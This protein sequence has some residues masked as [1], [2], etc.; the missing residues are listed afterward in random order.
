MRYSL[1][2]VA[3]S[4]EVGNSSSWV[5]S[6]RRAGESSAPDP[7]EFNLIKS[8]SYGFTPALDVDYDQFNVETKTITVGPGIELELPVLNKGTKSI[9]VTLYDSHEKLIRNAMRSWVKDYLQIDKGKA[10]SFADLQKRALILDIDHFDVTLG[11]IPEHTQ[12]SFYVLP[13]G[14]LTFRGDQS[15]QSDTLPLTFLVVGEVNR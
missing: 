15:F 10:P 1:N 7:S 9:T 13:K 6:F 4:L 12:D 2:S 5:L 8:D 3:S 14:Q 11:S